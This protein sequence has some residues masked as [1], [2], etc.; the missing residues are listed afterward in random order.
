MKKSSRIIVAK[1]L[2]VCEEATLIRL[3][4]VVWDVFGMNLGSISATNGLIQTDFICS[5][6]VVM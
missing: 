3:I 6:T 4:F 2:V 1:T 5:A